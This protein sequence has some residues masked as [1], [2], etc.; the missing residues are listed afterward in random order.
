MQRTILHQYVVAILI[1]VAAGACQYWLQ[2]FLGE[3]FP[4]VI[5]PLAV[6]AASWVGG[7]APGL[8]ATVACTLAYLNLAV[9]PATGAGTPW[10]SALVLP[11]A[12]LLVGV[13]ISLGISRLREETARARRI[14]AET[15]ARLALTEQLSQL[16]SVLS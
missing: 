14:Q 11:L 10:V 4:L 16:S 5:F 8:G 13:L 15:E 1:T 6:L 7:L 12:L 2:G 9:R 3:P